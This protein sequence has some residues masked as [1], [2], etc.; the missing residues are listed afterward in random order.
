MAAVLPMLMCILTPH[1]RRLRGP[2]RHTISRSTT[3]F[4]KHPS[5]VD[6]G[7]RFRKRGKDF[8][9][10]FRSGGFARILGRDWSTEERDLST[11]KRIL[12]LWC[13]R[14]GERELPRSKEVRQVD[15]IRRH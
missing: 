3:T 12:R 15:K 6:G 7:A 14:G 9:K 5:K 4:L 13:L 11:A 1:S 10:L 8:A 2:S